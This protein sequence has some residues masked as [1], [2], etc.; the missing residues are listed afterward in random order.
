MVITCILLILFNL[1]WPL[2]DPSLLVDDFRTTPFETPVVIPV[3]ENDLVPEGDQ[4]TIDSTSAIISNP[5]NGIVIVNND[6]TVTYIPNG[7]STG[8]D[9]FVYRACDSLGQCDN[10]NVVVL[11][12][13]DNNPPIAS[14]FISSDW[15]F[16]I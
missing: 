2:A 7:G 1:V 13:S 3:L 9:T 10:A 6:G 11:V 16:I 12:E 4:L 8:M 5:T 14:E 15:Y